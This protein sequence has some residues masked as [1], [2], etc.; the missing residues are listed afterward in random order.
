MKY[1]VDAICAGTNDTFQKQNSTNKYICKEIP[2]L[3]LNF[4]S[5]VL[6]FLCF[7]IDYDLPS[8]P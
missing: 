4:G 6:F 3:G 7:G 1:L 2:S 8:L 5:K